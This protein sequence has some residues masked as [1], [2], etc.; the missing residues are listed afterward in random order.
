MHDKNLD[1][2][3]VYYYRTVSSCKLIYFTFEES[4]LKKHF[5]EISF[6]KKVEDPSKAISTFNNIARKYNEEYEYDDFKYTNGVYSYFDK[7]Y[8]GEVVVYDRIKAYLH[9]LTQPLADKD[10]KTEI[11]IEHYLHNPHEFDYYLLEN[12]LWSELLYHKDFESIISFFGYADIKIYGFK[13]KTFYKETAEDL[14]RKT[15]KCPEKYKLAANIA[16]GCMHKSNGKNNRTTIAASIY[17]LNEWYMKDLKHRLEEAGYKIIAI[18]T[19]SIKIKGKYNEKD[20]IIDIGEELGQFR[21]EYQGLAKYYS[22]GHCEEDKVKWKGK[23]GYMINGNEP[24]MFV[25]N[26][27]KELKIYKEFAIYED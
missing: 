21:I 26:L 6:L 11:S 19:D 2:G 17:A 25:E 16:V 15:K 24:C 10:S 1:I 13:S 18:N 23:A 9:S 5:E 12:Q 4:K 3:K 20:G 8:R 14:F 7:E 22:V 27:E